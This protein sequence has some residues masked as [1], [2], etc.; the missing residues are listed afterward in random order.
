MSFGVEG[1]GKLETLSYIFITEMNLNK[2]KFNINYT[3]WG[4][5]NICF[6]RIQNALQCFCNCKMH[7]CNTYSDTTALNLYVHKNIIT[8]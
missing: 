7:Y 6:F 8:I 2:E 1:G 5:N 4:C 3:V